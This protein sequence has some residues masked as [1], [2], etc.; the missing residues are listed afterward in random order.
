MFSSRVLVMSRLEPEKDVAF[1]IRTFAENAPVTSCLIIV[2][3]GNERP[4]LESLVKTL[5]C[6]ERIFFEGWQDPSAYYKIADLVL[7]TSRYEG[8][9]LVIIE[10][11]AAGTPVISSDVGIAREAGA[12]VT[13]FD[14][15]PEKLVSWFHNGPREMHLK[16]YP[17]KDFDEYVQAYCD[18]IM[19]CVEGR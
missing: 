14:E 9:G 19:R 12:I 11:L 7:V 16:N 1:A 10:A 2:G 3:D 6:R 8:Y 4:S 18:D 13:S 15:F 17:Y 5:P